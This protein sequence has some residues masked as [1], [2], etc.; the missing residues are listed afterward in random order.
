MTETRETKFRY[1]T[2]T[3]DALVDLARSIRPRWD[4]P[5]LRK[6]VRD[7]LA[8]EDQPTIAE[9]AYAV[10]R[11]AENFA[12]ETPAVI[13]MDGP[14]WRAA[15]SEPR[16][17]AK[18]IRCD[19]CGTSHM[20]QEQHACPRRAERAHAHTDRL[21]AIVADTRADLCSHRTPVALCVECTAARKAAADA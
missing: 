20:P 11:V 4:V 7:A 14:H 19:R 18:G 13:A 15:A 17:G 12:V 9:L 3:F 6:A 21:R 5:G 1:T 2:A 8:R 16:E 10:L